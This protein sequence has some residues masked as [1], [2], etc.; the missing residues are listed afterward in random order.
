MSQGFGRKNGAAAPQPKPAAKAPSVD[1]EVEALIN[2]ARSKLDEEADLKSGKVYQEVRTR[3]PMKLELST[4]AYFYIG[5]GLLWLAGLY[6]LFSRPD[7]PS[8]LDLILT[9]VPVAGVVVA[10]QLFKKKASPDVN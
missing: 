1:D 7:V 3:E 8:L 10:A 2:A 9:Q 4:A 6:W 5:A